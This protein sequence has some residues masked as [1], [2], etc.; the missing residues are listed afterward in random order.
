MIEYANMTL[1]Y[2]YWITYFYL[3]FSI[4]FTCV[5]NFSRQA[6]FLRERKSNLVKLTN[7]TLKTEFLGLTLNNLHN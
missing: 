5:T 3:P 2:L 4:F 1:N 7:Y 6:I